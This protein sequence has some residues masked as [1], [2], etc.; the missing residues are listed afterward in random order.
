M[1]TKKISITDE[2]YNRLS[3]L[4]NEN[5]SFSEIIKRIT[6]KV[7]LSDFHGIISKDFADELEKNIKKSRNI[8]KKT[9]PRKI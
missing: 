9:S 8:H 2:A 1:G 4:K 7:K 6:G 5:E 3:N